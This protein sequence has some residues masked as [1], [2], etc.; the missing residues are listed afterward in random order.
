M[1]KTCQTYCLEDLG[2]FTDNA[3]DPQ[4]YGR[5]EGHLEIC[6][7]CR[8][9]VDQYRLMSQSFAHGVA[10]DTRQIDTQG[11][12]Q[13]VFQ[14]VQGNKIGFI[15][16]AIDYFSPKLYLK[17]A[18]IVAIMVIGFGYYAQR[19]MDILGPSAIV[20]SVDTNMSSVMIFETQKSKHTIIWFS[21]T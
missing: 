1:E 5:I 11:L 9:I 2:K 15:K 10:R 8:G 17:L 16:K 6:P 19:P 4:E 14:K 20:T 12:E 21:E 18:S 13:R 3:L 7:Q